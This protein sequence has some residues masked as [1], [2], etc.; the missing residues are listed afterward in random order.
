[1][2]KLQKITVLAVMIVSLVFLNLHAGEQKVVDK[3]FKACDLVKIKVVSGDCIVKKG[4]SSGI[5][6]HLTYTYPEDKYTPIMEVE[7]DTLILKEEFAKN[8]NIKGKSSWT[9][10]VPGKTNI[11]GKTASGD[12]TLSGLK[13][14][15]EVKVAS[16]D[17]K[18]EDAEG[19]ITAS[20][21][22]G[23]ITLTDSNG[24]IKLNTASGDIQ[25]GNCAGVIDANCASG[26]I[27]MSGIVFKGESSV[28]AVSGDVEVKLAKTCEYDL[29]LSTVSG[30]IILDY[31]GNSIKG[32]FKFSGQKGNIKSAV[33]LEGKEDSGCSPFTKRYF[34]KGGNSPQVKLKTISGNLALKK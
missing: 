26:D 23:E 14:D 17:I 29:D 3:S 24:K 6:V 19:N 9:V 7:G 11:E 22:S 13:S 10:T 34:T 21:A 33:P 31:N 12:F 16:G 28:K 25:A 20:A 5:D 4:K 32:H 18:I 2:K 1:M 15:V 8:K 27:G 30:D